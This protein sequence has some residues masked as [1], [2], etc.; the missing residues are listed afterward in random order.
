[1]GFIRCTAKRGS[2]TLVA[3]VEDDNA[4]QGKDGEEDQEG[5]DDSFKKKE[6]AIKRLKII[7]LYL[8]D[9]KEITETL[10]KERKSDA[11]NRQRQAALN[12]VTKPAEEDIKFELK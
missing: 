3:L 9:F 2:K 12:D 10:K 5:H 7:E 1:M 8:K 11:T 6:E 4:S